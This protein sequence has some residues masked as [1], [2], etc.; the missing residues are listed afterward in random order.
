MT[1]TSARNATKS[2]VVQALTLLVSL[3]F[4]TG[5]MSQSF[6]AIGVPLDRCYGL[7]QTWLEEMSKSEIVDLIST[8]RKKLGDE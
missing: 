2:Q 1:K 4:S 7:V 3:K 8:L 5:Y 6:R